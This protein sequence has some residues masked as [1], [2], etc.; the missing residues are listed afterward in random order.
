MQPIWVTGGKGF[1]G[2]HVAKLAA[3]HGHPVF[4]IGHGLWTQQASSAWRYCLWFNADIEAANLS[5]L[6]CESGVPDTIFHLAGGS[7]VGASFQ[8]PHEDFFRTVVTTARLLEWVRLNAPETKMVV[9]SSAAVYGAGHSGNIREEVKLAPFSPYGFHKAMMEDLCRSYGENFGVRV[10]VV[11]LFSVYG[12]GLEKQLLW[13]LCGK[14]AAARD[15]AVGLGGTG[16]EVRD[17]LHVSDAA[18]ML[19]LA[20]DHCASTTQVFNGGTQV[21]TRISDIANIVCRAWE[22]SPQV[23]FSGVA[24][25]GDPAHLVA[26]IQAARSLGFLPAVTVEQGIVE[27]VSWFK[28]ARGSSSKP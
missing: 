10:A 5:L 23:V 4:G 14:L 2:R 20:R 8:S 11:R 18:R 1:I 15:Q 13:D 25:K 16:A 28:S 22:G 7:S 26:D 27:T 21:G 17:W 12:A 19:W 9:A 6:M 24:R 3:G